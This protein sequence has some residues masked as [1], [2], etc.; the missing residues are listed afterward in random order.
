MLRMYIQTD[1]RDWERLLPALEL[2]YNA[3]S[4]SSTELSPF[5]IM[6]GQ[7]PITAAD[8][9]V[10]GNL[11]PTLTP[12]MTKIFQQLCDRAQRHILKAKWQQKQYADAHRRDVRYTPG[13]KL[14]PDRPRDPLM[15]AKEAAVGWL[16]VQGPDGV[17]TDSYEVDYIL[18]QRASIPPNLPTTPPFARTGERWHAAHRQ[19]HHLRLMPSRNRRI[20]SKHQQATEKLRGGIGRHECWGKEDRDYG[21]PGVRKAKGERSEDSSGEDVREFKRR[22]EFSDRWREISDRGGRL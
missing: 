21:E 6:I 15:Q 22:R 18:N 14:V 2:A 10:V 9:D 3:T 12:P 5:E 13:D 16:P 19:S 7:N 11:A 4:H 1:E 8:L 20:D 17:P